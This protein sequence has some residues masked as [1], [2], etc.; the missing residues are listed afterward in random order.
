MFNSVARDIGSRCRALHT[1]H[2]SCACVFDFSS[3]LHFVLFTVSLIFYFILLIFHFTSM[4]VGSE[5][6]PMCASA[7]EESDSLVNNTLSQE[8]RVPVEECFDCF[9]RI[10]SK[11]TNS[12]CEKWH[13]PECLF[14]KSES[15]CRFGEKYSYAHRHSNLS[16]SRSLSWILVCLQLATLFCHSSRCLGL[17]VT[18]LPF[19]LCPLPSVAACEFILAPRAPNSHHLCNVR[20]RFHHGLGCLEELPARPRA[21]PCGLLRTHSHVLRVSRVLFATVS[22]AWSWIPL[23]RVWST[24][25]RRRECLVAGASASK[26]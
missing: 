15:G 26:V 11:D 12:F 13:P 24:F 14:Y 5:R 19:E 23:C 17:S 6:I 18:I 25:V 22:S 3:T 10:T 4:W 9:A 1:I 20:T 7:N 16:S 8:A 21:D 2:V